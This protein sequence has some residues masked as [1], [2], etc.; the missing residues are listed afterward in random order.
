MTSRRTISLTAMHV[1]AND[2]GFLA[3]PVAVRE[4]TIAPVER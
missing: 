1:V 3:L 4:L 2:N